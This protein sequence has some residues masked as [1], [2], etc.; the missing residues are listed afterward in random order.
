LWL[1]K[2]TAD[3]GMNGDTL[4]RE[5]VAAYRAHYGDHYKTTLSSVKLDRVKDVAE[6]FSRVAA[7]LL[8]ASDADFAKL[9]SVRETSESYGQPD[10]EPKYADID[11]FLERRAK[12]P[13]AG[14]SLK[15]VIADARAAVAKA[16]AA[17]Y[18]SK[19]LE[20]D[21]GSNGLSVFFPESPGSFL[22]DADR[23]GYFPSNKV[24]RVEFVAT[25]PW[26]CVVLRFAKQSDPLCK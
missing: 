16:V 14:A 26:A 3:P 8:K 7:Q 5:I 6:T 2:L 11:L 15:A 9:M 17:N 20:G 1:G 22:A 23:A 19:R 18:R 12:H 10:T 13:V 24:A 21:Y 25:N 4:A